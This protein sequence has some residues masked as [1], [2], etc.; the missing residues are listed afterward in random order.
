MI[1][2][3]LYRLMIGGLLVQMARADVSA[4]APSDPSDGGRRF[5]LRGM[6]FR[7]NR[8]LRRT[9]QIIAD[10][11][12][13]TAFF[14]TGFVEDAVSII[15]QHLKGQ[16]Y[17][18]P[19]VWV[20]AVTM[21]GRKLNFV[22]TRDETLPL[23][24]PLEIRRVRFKMVPGKIH[25]YE[26]LEITGLT[27]QRR[28]GVPTLAEAEAFFIPGGLWVRARRLRIFTETRLRQSM[29]NLR[30]A[31]R[32]Q[33]YRDAMVSGGVVALDTR[34]GAVRVGVQVETGPR[35]RVRRLLIRMALDD[36]A[37]DAMPL[38]VETVMGPWSRIW[39]QD[40]VI[41]LRNGLYAQG[42][43]DARCVLEIAAIEDVDGEKL[44]D[45]TA[46][47]HSGP[48]LTTGTV[49]FEGR[50][51]TRERAMRRRLMIAPGDPLNPLAVER[52]RQR[53]TAMGSFEQVTTEFQA[54]NRDVAIR[55]VVF[56]VEEGR[57]IE[58]SLMAGYG[59]YE[60][61][62][63]GLEVEQFNLWGEG[64]RSRLLAVQSF[65]STEADYVYTVPE[66]L[67]E[68][69]SGF[70][71]I[72][73][74]RRMEIDFL[75][76]EFGASTGVRRY[77]P[78]LDVDFSLRYT[79]EFLRSLRF[80]AAQE[81]GRTEV[82]VGAL[83]ADLRR[84]RQDNPVYPTRG[85]QAF[86]RAELAAEA[87]GGQAQYL[88]WTFGGAVHRP[89]GGGRVW[90]IGLN[91]GIIHAMGEQRDNLPFNKRFFPGGDRSLRGYRYGEAA[92]LNAEGQIIGSERFILLQNEIEQALTPSLNLLVFC[93]ILQINEE[94][95]DY[96]SGE[97]LGSAGI[98]L[99]YRTIV[100]P[101]RLEYGYNWRRRDADPRD[102][103]HLSIGFPFP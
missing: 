101:V 23:P 55:D 50:Q 28:E 87:L 3:V 19:R 84:S 88:L 89:I 30:E 85:S 94:L 67:T 86:T 31:L 102:M 36:V 97:L 44:M 62:R 49:R 33:G 98:G 15:L 18:Q 69:I 38:E 34:S 20:R 77:L 70:A 26:R 58:V 66:F 75:R 73:A 100:G 53:L 35:Y 79:C 74:L 51:H 64:H 40:T 99:R 90:H 78:A 39:E 63:G 1:R 37:D 17:L 13:H 46:I 10:G 91:H 24:R 47:L 103:L 29:E 56:K 11:D 16:G 65:K 48:A 68:Q 83:S 8:T 21:E 72:S 14:D 41:R 27:G 52:S 80:D 42:Y 61:L 43:A 60:L 22:R 32:R 6:G 2:R 96:P 71:R 57:R 25:Y 4:P 82:R 92:S 54:S 12:Q 76:R 45:M 5:T 93:D 59:S 95:K 9:V 81:V 7:A